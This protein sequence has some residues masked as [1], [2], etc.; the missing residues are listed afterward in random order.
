[1]NVEDWIEVDLMSLMGE[2][3]NLRFEVDDIHDKLIA[4]NK[5]AGFYY[6]NV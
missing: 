6:T 4:M 1:M 5:A 3:E 2:E